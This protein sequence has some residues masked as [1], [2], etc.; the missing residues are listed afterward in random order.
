MA[1]SV[2]WCLCVCLLV[3]LS[4]QPQILKKKIQNKIKFPLC[5]RRSQSNLSGAS[6]GQ[7]SD[8]NQDDH[9]SVYTSDWYRFVSLESL[10]LIRL[11]TEHLAPR[12]SSVSISFA[13]FF[14]VPVS[15]LCDPPLTYTHN[16]VCISAG[17]VTHSCFFS[18][19]FNYQQLN[20]CSCLPSA[21]SWFV[22]HLLCCSFAHCRHLVMCCSPQN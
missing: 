11:F 21:P 22:F 4:L 6:G 19:S 20:I 17:L 18:P 3:C 7:P 12:Q 1:V 5:F 2:V 14:L 16:S 8:W 9:V 15:P 13:S 10:H